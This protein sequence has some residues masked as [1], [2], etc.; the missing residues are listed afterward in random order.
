MVRRIG[1]M[2]FM[3]L[4]NKISFWITYSDLL[5]TA[6]NRI[7]QRSLLLTDGVNVNKDSL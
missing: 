4:D 5:A 1:S 7:I 3:T 2:T 6:L